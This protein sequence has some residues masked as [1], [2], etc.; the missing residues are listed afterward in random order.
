[1]NEKLQ[2]NSLYGQIRLNKVERS[3]ICQLADLIN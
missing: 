3:K 1:M 2:G